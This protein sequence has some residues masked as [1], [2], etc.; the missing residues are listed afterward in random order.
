M[1]HLVSVNLSS[2]EGV[3]TVDATVTASK[4]SSM[5]SRITRQYVTSDEGELSCMIRRDRLLPIQAKVAVFGIL[6]QRVIAE[7]E[8][9]F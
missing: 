1:K 4:T 3:H 5:Q 8:L 2:N 6:V 9:S 7:R